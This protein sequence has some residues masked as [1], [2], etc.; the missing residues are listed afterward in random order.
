LALPALVLSVLRCLTL[1]ILLRS[2]LSLLLQPALERFQV[3]GQLPRAIER[4]F[5]SL[6]VTAAAGG[7]ALSLLQV[8]RNL[9]QIILDF[10]LA[11]A[12][13]IVPFVL[14]QL[15]ALADFVGQSISLDGI[16]CLS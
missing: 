3:V 6:G 16:G 7:A 15:I 5:H 9:V 2:V 4:L 14:Q 11:L 13:L 12:S 8:A 10:S 1:L